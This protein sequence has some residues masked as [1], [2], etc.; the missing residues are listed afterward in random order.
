MQESEKFCN[1]VYHVDN[2]KRQ[3]HEYNLQEIQM[4]NASGVK[5]TQMYADIDFQIREYE[6]EQEL[7]DLNLTAKTS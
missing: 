2:A 7:R 4:L 5:S 3:K 6:E 1:Y